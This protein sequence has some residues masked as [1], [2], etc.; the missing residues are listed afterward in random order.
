M[1]ARHRARLGSPLRLHGSFELFGKSKNLIMKNI[2][3]F[4]PLYVV[5]FLFNFHAWDSTP[6]LGG[7]KGDHWTRYSWFGSGYSGTVPSFLF[8]SI[9]GFGIFW[10]LFVIAA[11]TIVQIMAQEAQLE[12]TEGKALH[13]VK[14]WAVVKE[15]GWRMFGL[16]LLMGLYI[17]VGLILFIIPGL[18]MLRRYFLAPYVMLDTRCGITEAMERSAELSKPYSGYIWGMIGVMFL[19]SLFNVVEG[20][21]WMAAFVLGMLYSVAPA[22][23]YQELKEIHGP[24]RKQHIHHDNED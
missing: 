2:W 4:G 3:I 16:Y 19:I 21:G 23:R 9:I 15:L 5:P 24:F 14:L 22:L 6:A 1:T 11:G 20:I 13:F 10:F 7:N 8:Y 18:I 12:A 17:F